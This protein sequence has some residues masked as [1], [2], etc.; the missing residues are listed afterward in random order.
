MKSRRTA[1]DLHDR[2][3][4]QLVAQ[5]RGRVVKALGD[6]YLTVFHSPRQALAA[7]VAIATSP[8]AARCRSDRRAHGRGARAGR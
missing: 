4:R 6:G 3:V 8:R 1:F 2:L 7:A 5:H